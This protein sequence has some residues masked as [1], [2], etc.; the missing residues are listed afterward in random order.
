[1]KMF[2]LGLMGLLV[3]GAAVAA[4]AQPL[5]SKS[6]GGGFMAPEHAGFERC[7]VFD[8]K[9]VITH[10]YGMRTPTAL[11]L[12]EERKVELKGDVKLVI[13]KAKAE[14]IEEKGNFL[15]D[16][17]ATSVTAF[18]GDE[19]ILL[20]STGGCGSPRKQRNGVYSNKLRQITDLYCAVT[21]DFSHEE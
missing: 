3:T 21:Y 9:V 13:E 12:V 19:Q 16:G 8:D 17:P 7:E 5:I 6:S 18:N 11:Q 4:P 2:V 20:Y 14:A 10:Q 15:C 1:M